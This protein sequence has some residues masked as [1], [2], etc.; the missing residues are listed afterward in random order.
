LTTSERIFAETSSQQLRQPTLIKSTSFLLVQG[1]DEL[2]LVL[3]GADAV[4][5]LDHK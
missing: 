5:F 4:C 1:L 3:K 2:L